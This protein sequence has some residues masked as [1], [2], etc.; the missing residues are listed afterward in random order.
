MAYTRRPLMLLEEWCGYVPLGDEWMIDSELP[1][2]HI[3]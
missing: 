3:L 1:I 2:L